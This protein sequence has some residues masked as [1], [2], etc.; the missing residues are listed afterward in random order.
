MYLPSCRAPAALGASGS[1][2][3]LFLGHVQALG[4]LSLSGDPGAVPSEEQ[5]PPGQ[6]RGAL[7]AG[8]GGHILW[9][10][11]VK[12]AVAEVLLDEMESREEC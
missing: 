6:E 5:Q 10:A 12:L 1:G 8:G 9:G 2:S 7:G 4:F 3:G 11:G